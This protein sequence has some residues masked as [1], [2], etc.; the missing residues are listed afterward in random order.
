MDG[1]VQRI[2][3]V[4]TW[5]RDHRD[6]LHETATL[7]EMAGGLIGLLGGIVGTW[8][9]IRNTGGP[10]ERAFVVRACVVVWAGGIVFLA[11]WRHLLWIPYGILLP[12]GIITWNRAQQRIRREETE[13]A[14]E[15]R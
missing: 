14:K 5:L 4:A 13:G 2:W 6:E 12:L 3:R 7:A 15:S 10:R 9:S 11:P 8:A 1:I